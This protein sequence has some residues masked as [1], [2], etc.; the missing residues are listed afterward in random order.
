MTDRNAFAVVIFAGLTVL[1]IVV[2]GI[3]LSASD[4]TLDRELV[5]L[6]GVA[7]GLLGGVLAP[8]PFAQRVHVTNNA[9]DPVPVEEA[10]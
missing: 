9:A 4:K 7:L 2:G 5:A 1:A 6:A 3:Y 10:P 8:S